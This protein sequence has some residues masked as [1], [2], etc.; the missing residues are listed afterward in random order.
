MAKWHKTN[1]EKVRRRYEA[2]QREVQGR[3]WSPKE[4]KNLVRFLPAYK[5]GGE[6][7]LETSIHF[8]VKEGL[9][10]VCNRFYGEPCYICE[11][12]QK[13]R[14]SDDPE[15][16]RRAQ[17]IAPRRRVFYNIVD[18]NDR[19]AGV[20]IYASGASVFK[21]LLSYFYDP[22]WGDLTDP[23][24][25]YDVVI[26]RRGT[27]LDTEYTVR[28][29]KNPSPIDDEEWLN[30]LN[31][32]DN[33]VTR[34]SYEEQKDLL[35]GQLQSEEMEPDEVEPSDLSEEVENEIEQVEVEGDADEIGEDVNDI[36]E[37]EEVV[38]VEEPECF[39]EFDKRDPECKSCS[40]KS[41]CK[42]ATYS[43]EKLRK[44][45]EQE[46]EKKEKQRRSR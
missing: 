9:H 3:F 4:G 35:S 6:F 33:L 1:L 28:P 13:L 2:L 45:L 15:D 46:L 29:R 20:Q 32:L 41:R 26:E 42:R 24:H 10:L 8:G 44:E 25:G 37:D 34:Y 7:Y 14:L 39:G 21:Q 27:G 17:R 22:D 16:V 23:E 36:P 31:D 19:D 38:D 30:Q 12:V 40:F 5:E 43:K 18:L 11:L